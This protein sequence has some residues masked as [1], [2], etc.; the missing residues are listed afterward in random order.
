MT[1]GQF[2][3]DLCKIFCLV[4]KIFYPAKVTIAIQ[5]GPG[6]FIQRGFQDDFV[7]VGWPKNPG[8]GRDTI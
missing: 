5:Q 1:T 7:S 6:R 4:N 8:N 2:L 3:L